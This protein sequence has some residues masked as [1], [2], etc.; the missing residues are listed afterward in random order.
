MDFPATLDPVL[1]QFAAAFGIGGLVGLER[2]RHRQ[3]TDVEQF[4]GIR[5]FILIAEAGAICGWLAVALTSSMPIAAG[6]IATLV[7][8]GVSSFLGMRGQGHALGVTSEFGALV[9][10][11]LG[12]MTTMGAVDLA[13]MLGVVSSVVLAFKQ[14][15][16]SM[17]RG[18]SRDDVI[19]GLKLLVASVIVLPLLPDQ[20][21][22][23]WGV[24]RPW[25]LWLM[26]I[27]ISG[28]SFA[29]YVAIRRLGPGRGLTVTGALG[30]LVSSTAASVSIARMSNDEGLK[31]DAAMLGLLLAWVVMII[32]VAVEVAVVRPSLL[33]ELALPL[34]VLGVTC[35]ACVGV[36]AWRVRHAERSEGE[37]NIANP[38]ELLPAIQFAGL[39]AL[40]LVA[41]E[42]VRSELPEAWLYLVAGVSGLVDVD[43]IT[44]SL[45]EQV[46]SGLDANIA[47][48]GILIASVSNTLVKV[49]IVLVLAP[50]LR[51][52][53]ALVGLFVTAAAGLTFA[54]A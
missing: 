17:I 53:V 39:F 7:L 25:R 27:F 50:G 34:G 44:L 28:L 11:L 43:A 20:A 12:A 45:A 48:G 31:P 15:L 35:L 4:G 47:V 41:V 16:H 26:V 32:R 49:G 6:I 3:H 52:R 13:V 42:I 22:D 23:P 18:L 1:M 9:T 5:T 8:V 37:L 40:V 46:G 10:F 38:F 51:V 19:G 24:V 21:V 54:L 30:G 36:F 2:E 29:G 14:P 33:W